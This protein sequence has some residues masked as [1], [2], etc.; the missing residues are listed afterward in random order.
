MDR[1][2][3]V[4]PPIEAV[5]WSPV[6]PSFSDSAVLI[7]LALLLFGPKKLPVLARQLGKLMADFRRASNE[8]RTQMEEEL[9]ISEQADRQKKLDAIESAAPA[10]PALQANTIEPPAEATVDPEQSHPSPAEIDALSAHDPI[11]PATFADS[12][13]PETAPGDD[14]IDPPITPIPIATNGDLS[15]HPPATGLPIP[16]V[17]VHEAT[18]PEAELE[19][20]TLHG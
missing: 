17:P 5:S 4:S 12:A 19:T 8:F 9:R 18:V 6:M 2:K 14:A 16:N 11:E 15:L 13:E 20:E 3:F 1:G 10:T 7:V